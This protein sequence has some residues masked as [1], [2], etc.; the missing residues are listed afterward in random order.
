MENFFTSTSP[1]PVRAIEDLRAWSRFVAGY[2]RV[3]YD[4]LGHWFLSAPSM[5]AHRQAGA[6]LFANYPSYGGTVTI[7]RDRQGKVDLLNV[8]WETIGHF[9]VYVCG[10]Y[11][12]D[13]SGGDMRYAEEFPHCRNRRQR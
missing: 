13:C 8:S 2:S 11:E 12:V 4:N 6:T 10:F 9:V 5:L 7:P 3:E 1:D